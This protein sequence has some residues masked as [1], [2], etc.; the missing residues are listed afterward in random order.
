VAIAGAFCPS[1]F[2]VTSDTSSDRLAATTT[3]C[4]VAARADS[5]TLAAAR[6]CVAAP[7]AWAAAAPKNPA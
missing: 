2:D 1:R 3:G 7:D 5:N 6:A 4:T